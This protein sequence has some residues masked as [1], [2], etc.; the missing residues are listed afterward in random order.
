M[1][2]TNREEAAQQAAFARAHLGQKVAEVAIMLRQKATEIEGDI[3]AD[4]ASAD[5]LAVFENV[6]RSLTELV[7]A[8]KVYELPRIALGA[9]EA[10][11]ALERFSE[12]KPRASEPSGP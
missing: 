3:T 8:L 6:S 1:E 9:I 4:H 5:P 11:R 12:T 2:P 10:Q 7:P